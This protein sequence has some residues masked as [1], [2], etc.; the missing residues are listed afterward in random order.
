MNHEGFVLSG[1]I[2]FCAEYKITF[3]QDEY[4]PVKKQKEF[5]DT[6]FGS[7]VSEKNRRTTL[8]EMRKYNY[9]LWMK[10]KT[11][12]DGTAIRI[13]KLDKIFD[14]EFEVYLLK[15]NVM[16]LYF[17]LMDV[18]KQKSSYEN[19]KTDIDNI[20]QK[21]PRIKAEQNYGTIVAFNL[22]EAELW[23]SLSS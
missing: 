17:E 20:K 5:T 14:H 7:G 8:C 22:D 10:L 11:M 1:L 3:D 19:F 23:K 18:I 9:E 21:W 16:F 6:L 4:D 13:D 12:S 15:N 2:A